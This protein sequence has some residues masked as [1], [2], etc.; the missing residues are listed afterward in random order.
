M[1]EAILSA[2]C[3]ASV[4]FAGFVLESNHASLRIEFSAG[5]KAD[6]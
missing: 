4:H 5:S 3:K 6:R 1:H 2:A